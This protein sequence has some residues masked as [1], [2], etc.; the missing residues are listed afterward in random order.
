MFP[1]LTGFNIPVHEFAP[2]NGASTWVSCR[3]SMG[4]EKDCSWAVDALGR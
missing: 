3:F 4:A 1:P 2:K